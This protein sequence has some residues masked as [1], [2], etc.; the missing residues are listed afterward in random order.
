MQSAHYLRIVL[1]IRKYSLLT[2]FEG[3]WGEFSEEVLRW[4]ERGIVGMILKVIKK[5]T[6]NKNENKESF[7]ERVVL[8]KFMEVDFQ[9]RGNCPWWVFL[10]EFPLGI[11][12]EVWIFRGNFSPEGGGGFLGMI[13]KRSEIKKKIST[14]SKDEHSNLRLIKI[15]LH[16]MGTSPCFNP[17]LK[18]NF[19]QKCLRVI[20][21]THWPLNWNKKYSNT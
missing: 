11:S 2:F 4:G 20:S 1:V 15:I 8:R 6:F 16:M 21:E 19:C 12:S 18:F 5:Q 17:R 9:R 3:R 7:P 13:W 10:G 14:E